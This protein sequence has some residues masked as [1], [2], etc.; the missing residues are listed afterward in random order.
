M[1][2]VDL[3]GKL[4][5]VTGGAQGIG[6]A[7]VAACAGAGADV[8]IADIQ[9]AVAE[10]TAQQVATATGQRVIA[11]SADVTHLD[12]IQQMA[13]Q[14][15][16]RWGRI[17]VLINNAGWDQFHFFLQTTPDF[18]DKVININ[19][20]SV[21]NTCYTVLPQMVAQK[22]GVIIN[23]ASDAGR[24]GSMGEAVYSG[25]KGAVIA[26]SKTLAREHARDNIRVNVIAPGITETA[27]LQSLRETETGEKVV[28]AVAK[29]IP[30]GRRAGEA[31][32]I[33]PA[34]A[35]LASDAARYITGQVLSVNGG[36]TMVD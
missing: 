28:T 35:F 8:V 7:I 22:S 10:Q 2:T 29:S 23:M 26:F 13:G 33:S 21:L 31:E 16:A 6:R 27:L 19:Y 36:L 15:I 14:A 30:L 4:V 24:V 34:V 17:D 25:C 9:M 20:K 12:S 18:W 11:I 32:E 5:I 3:T 1:N